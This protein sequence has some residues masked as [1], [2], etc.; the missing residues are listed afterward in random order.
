MGLRRKTESRRCWPRAHAN[1]VNNAR[2]CLLLAV[3]LL[4][5]CYPSVHKFWRVT[6]PGAEYRKNT[7]VGYV[8]TYYEYH[9]IHI[10]V[11]LGDSGY[12]L[13]VYY[14]PRGATVVV[15]DKMLRLRSVTSTGT[16]DEALQL[17]P[18]LAGLVA[19]SRFRHLGAERMA[20]DNFGPL[21]GSD[22][23]DVEFAQYIYGVDSR[24]GA[25]TSAGTLTLPSLTIN[26]QV[27]DP[28]DLSF[29]RETYVG[30]LPVNC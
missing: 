14:L 28:Q 29:K 26:G 13:I 24:V 6:L 8:T 5:G 27:Y 4:S 17:R 2:G 15:N 25:D 3:F 11:S 16:T 9:G 18:A 19:T 20:S 23:P 22:K 10:S 21:V 12:P 1:I 30:A 7:C